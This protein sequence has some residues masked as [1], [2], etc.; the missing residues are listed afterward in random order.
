MKTR[1]LLA[2]ISI[3]IL[4]AA[5]S[6]ISD[7]HQIFTPTKEKLVIAT[8]TSLYDTGLL[9]VLEASFEEEYPQYDVSFIAAGT[10]LALQYASRGDADAVLVHAPLLEAKFMDEG[11]GVNR[12]IFAYNFFVIIGPKND[13]AKIR[14]LNAVEAL[15]RIAEAGRRG[16]ACWVSRGDNS[17]THTKE[18]LLWKSAGFNP[19]ELKGEEWYIESGAGMGRTLLLTNEVNAYTISDIGTYTKYWKEN[20]IQLEILVEESEELINV[21]SF[22]AVNPNKVEDVNFKAAMKFADFLVSSRC[23]E[24]I[25]EFGVKDYG[26]PLFKPAVPLLKGETKLQ[27]AEWIKKYGFINGEEC[28]SKYRLPCQT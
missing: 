21:Y 7:F 15:K 18:K 6:I 12:R 3:I 27:E 25:G 14:G 9:D 8:T 22:I 16:E 4:V 19:D 20:L 1:I 24:L 17:G 28:P 10:G 13:P 23:Q 2:V 5:V 11:Y 26:R